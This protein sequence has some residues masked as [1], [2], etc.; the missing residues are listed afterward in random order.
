MLFVKMTEVLVTVFLH[1]DTDVLVPSDFTNR[2]RDLVTSVVS[3]VSIFGD[4]A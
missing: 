2:Y 1:G 4:S 3:R